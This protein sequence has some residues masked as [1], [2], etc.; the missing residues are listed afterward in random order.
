MAYEYYRNFLVISF[1]AFIFVLRGHGDYRTLDYP[2]KEETLSHHSSFICATTFP[3]HQLAPSHHRQHRHHS[4]HTLANTPV[5]HVAPP[6]RT[7]AHSHHS[8]TSRFSPSPR[9]PAVFTPRHATLPLSLTRLTLTP[10]LST[11]RYSPSP[12]TW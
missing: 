10:H 7:P 9:P 6:T 11:S 8:H 12:L 1:P 4:Q 5:T 3:Y 2:R